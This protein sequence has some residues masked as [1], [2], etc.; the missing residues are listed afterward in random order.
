[1]IVTTTEVPALLLIDTNV[2]G[3]GSMH[4]FR[5]RD[6]SHGGWWSTVSFKPTHVSVV[7]CGVPGTFSANDR[8]ARLA[9]AGQG[10][11]DE[12]HTLGP[13]SWA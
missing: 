2:L 12:P 1:M 9:D 4:Q 8:G 13:H 11:E 5:Y 3:I 7:E 10:T 6:L